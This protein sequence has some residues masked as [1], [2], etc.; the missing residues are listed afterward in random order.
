M[1]AGAIYLNYTDLILE[2]DAYFLIK[3]SNF[4]NNLALYGNGGGLV[5]RFWPIIFSGSNLFSNNE[6]HASGGGVYYECSHYLDD[7]FSEE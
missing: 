1:S 5:S 6:A 3:N 7:I 4:K 2:D